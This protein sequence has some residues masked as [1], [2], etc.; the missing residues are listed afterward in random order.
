MGCNNRNATKCANCFRGGPEPR[1]RSALDF[2][3]D[4]WYNGEKVSKAA[5]NV[6]N[7]KAHK[8]YHTKR[9]TRYG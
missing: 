6:K 8:A 7:A 4:T 5:Q 3:E 9:M 2:P 1:P